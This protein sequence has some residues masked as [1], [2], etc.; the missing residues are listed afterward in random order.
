MKIVAVFACLLGMAAQAKSQTV[1][2]GDPCPKALFSNVTGLPSLKK[3][4]AP[5]KGKY[6][7]LGLWNTHCDVGRKLLPE[8][9][10]LRKQFQKDLEVLLIT[11]EGEGEVRKVLSGVPYLQDVRIPIAT[12]DTVFRRHFP[13]RTEPHFIWVNPQGKVIEITGHEELTAENL[14]A[15]CSGRPHSLA[16]K[17]EH[18]DPNI[19][20]SLTPLMINEYPEH[21]NSLVQY[22]YLGGFRSGIGTLTNMARFDM[23]DSTVRIVAVNQPVGR[24]YRLAFQQMRNFHASQL[25]FEGRSAGTAKDDEQSR[26]CYDLV[27][28]DTSVGKA[29]RWMKTDL[30]RAF[31]VKS[32]MER[33]KRKVYVLKRINSL[34]K[35]KAKPDR[36]PDVYEDEEKFSVQNISLRTLVENNLNNRSLLPYPV[37]N[38]TGYNGMVDLTICHRVEDFGCVRASFQAY[39]LDLV[40]EERELPVIVLVKD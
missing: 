6:W 37:V 40:E 24:L 15:F 16:V 36:A 8:L 19:Y 21:K 39:G 38:E 30:D 14:A 35:F 33:Q 12:G 22:S 25:V 1:G 2:I 27:L 17:K 26:F 23:R 3:I 32:R 34:E 31:G 13:H 5:A 10:A 29:H 18:S 9:S 28:K 7:L 4:K 11:P 20:H